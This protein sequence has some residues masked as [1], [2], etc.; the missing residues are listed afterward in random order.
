MSRQTRRSLASNGCAKMW[1][2]TRFSPIPSPNFS[3]AVPPLIPSL[4]R[5]Q[6]FLL[7]SLTSPDLAVWLCRMASS[8]QPLYPI[9]CL[10]HVPLEPSSPGT[11]APARQRPMPLHEANRRTA[12]ACDQ[13]GHQTLGGARIHQA[14]ADEL[15]FPSLSLWGNDPFGQYVGHATFSDG[16]SFCG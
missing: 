14:P 10:H 2:Q 8:P 12:P 5:F 4:T 6:R 13:M 7:I 3:T 1:S 11:H 9:S 16:C 15:V